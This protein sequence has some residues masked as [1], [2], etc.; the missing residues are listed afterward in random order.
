MKHD[1]LV[2]NKMRRGF[3]NPEW[4]TAFL[5]KLAL[6]RDIVQHRATWE[7]MMDFWILVEP[8]T[9]L[10]TARVFDVWESYASMGHG[11]G[12]GQISPNAIE[13]VLDATPSIEHSDRPRGG[14]QRKWH[15][16]P[17]GRGK[18]DL[19]LSERMAEWKGRNLWAYLGDSWNNPVEW[20]VLHAVLWDPRH[21]EII[22]ERQEEYFEDQLKEYGRDL[23]IELGM[24]QFDPG[25]EASIT[26]RRVM[27]EE[28]RFMTALYITEM[29][30]C[31]EDESK[32]YELLLEESSYGSD[33]PSLA[34]F[35][36]M[37]FWFQFVEDGTYCWWK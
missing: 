13:D 17:I 2:A 19:G 24:P 27:C 15:P 21:E 1:Y 23:L 25:D 34:S 5:T 29:T 30:E 28:A 9:P 20:V 3:K 8:L 32:A 22:Q 33:D 11:Y 31:D 37:A 26:H 36:D 6:L 10:M 14:G 16:G 18:R 4:R 12:Q 35:R 7:Q